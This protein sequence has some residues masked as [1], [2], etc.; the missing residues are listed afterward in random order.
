MN[1]VNR[2]TLACLPLVVAAL[3][4]SGSSTAVVRNMSTVANAASICQSALP[5]FDGLIRKRPL[6]IQNEGT[7]DAFVTCPMIL[8]YSGGN[9][10]LAVVHTRS[11]DGVAHQV[12]CTGVSG[13]ATGDTNQS[14]VK[15]ITVNASGTQS[16]LSWSAGDF[17]G[18][19]IEF[20]SP[21]FSLSCLLPPGTGLKQTFLNYRLDVGT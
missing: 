18:P 9:P 21:F 8:V 17:T 2:A 1:R 13:F 19:G 20:P 10:T 14:V 3:A 4:Y 11:N 16:V 6:A 12:S 5:A 15:T 7:S